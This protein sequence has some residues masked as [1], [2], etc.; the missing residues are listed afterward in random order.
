MDAETFF[1]SYLA[2]PIVMFFWVCGYLWKGQGWLKLSQIDVDSGR[3]EID[4]EAH[5]RKLEQRRNS[6]LWKRVCWKFF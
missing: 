1:K 6:P 3:R 2:A 5:N 4:W